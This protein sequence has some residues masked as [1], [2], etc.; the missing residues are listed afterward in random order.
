[1]KT[2]LCGDTHGS[3]DIHKLNTKNFPEQRELT[4]DDVV[5][6][7]GDFG[8]YW[9]GD[10]EE[11]YWLDWLTRKKFTFAFLDGNHENHEMIWELP[12]ETRWGGT[13]HVD[14][15]K[16]GE[17]IYLKRGEIYTINNKKF[18]VVGGA[19]SIDKHLRTEG[20]DWWATEELSQSDID[21]TLDNLDLH[22]R[23]VDYVLSHTCPESLVL[24]FCENPI[25]RN[26]SVAKFLEHVDNITEFQ[27]WHFG[28][29]H[30]DWTHIQDGIKYTCY[31]KEVQEL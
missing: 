10:K 3:H 26:D 28:H 4:K 1:M 29:F 8:N 7:L 27:S 24:D 16:Y 21:N 30:R 15:R 31:Y 17:I 20:K 25:R 12:T 23:K 6:Q 14:K 13:V 11:K 5:I 9:W 18:L 2:F 22:K 19:T